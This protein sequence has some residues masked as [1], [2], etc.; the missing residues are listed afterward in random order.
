M[1]ETK[2][3][4]ISREDIPDMVKR[5]FEVRGQIAEIKAGEL[6]ELSDEL[7]T[8]ENHLVFLMEEGEK[9]S[10]DGAGTVSAKTEVVPVVDDWEKVYEHIHKEKAFYLLGRKLLAA[11]FR[12]ALLQGLEIPGVSS[13]K[14]SKLNVRKA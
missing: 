3:L 13:T 7:K 5:L 12:E 6:K 9:I 8:L 14:I 11:P 2:T 10:F 4:D 1:T